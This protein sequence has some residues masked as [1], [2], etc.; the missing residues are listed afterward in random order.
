MC[1]LLR[2]S[3]CGKKGRER[4]LFTFLHLS[5]KVHF[6]RNWYVVLTMLIGTPFSLK[7][8]FFLKYNFLLKTF[9]KKY[10]F[11]FIPTWTEML[12]EIHGL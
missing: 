8:P 11:I 5:L 9:L 12:R 2:I 1:V 6:L 4:I 3:H 10:P 7:Y